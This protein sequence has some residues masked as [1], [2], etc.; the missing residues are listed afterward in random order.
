[1]PAGSAASSADDAKGGIENRI[2]EPL[3]DVREIERDV[4]RRS[5]AKQKH[6]C[7]IRRILAGRHRVRSRCAIARCEIRDERN[8]R[9]GDLR[10]VPK[11]SLT[12]RC[13]RSRSI[14]R[15]DIQTKLVRGFVEALARY[16]RCNHVA[17]AG[18]RHLSTSERSNCEE[19][20]CWMHQMSCHI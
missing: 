19:L 6:G 8:L 18:C 20:N 10:Y 12:G 4:T 13:S 14:E 1:M 2:V 17:T 3:A 7:W 16:G 9:R 11:S 5:D 15:R